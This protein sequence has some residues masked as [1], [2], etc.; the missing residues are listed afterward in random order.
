M[1]FAAAGYR[2]LAPKFEVADILQ[3]YLFK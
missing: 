2:V 1:T 3:G